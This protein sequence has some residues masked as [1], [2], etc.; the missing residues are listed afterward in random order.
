MSMSTTD[1][2]PADDEWVELEPTQHLDLSDSLMAEALPTLSPGVAMAE[3]TLA[4]LAGETDALRRRRLFAAAI[5]LAATF[6]LL[7][8]WVFASD[9]PGTLTA[10]GSRYSVRVLLLGLR[11]LLAAII[12]G[13]L[14]SEIPLGR[15][16]L[17]AI[18]YVLFLGVTLLM[19]A[20]QYFVNLDLARRGPE[21]GPIILAIM[22]YGVIQMMAL[23]M[24]YGT[25]IPNRPTV[26]ARAL[27]IMLIVPIALMALLRMHPDIAG[28]VP[29]LSEAEEA[30][31][32][33]LFL[34]IGA[35]LA[36]YGSFLLNGL[37]VELHQSRMLA[38]A[39]WA[40]TPVR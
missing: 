37:R 33:I 8:V 6:G 5:F 15:K 4:S 35:A 38:T 7:T 20:S 25:L 22:N 40:V 28:I 13:L 26:A 30:G 29:Q 27:L 18:E 39:V 10:E 12:A 3:G 11:C 17:R 2:L 9:N 23:M 21:Y 36:L 19:M 34:A 32:N 24:I 16:S 14:A 1:D 31:S